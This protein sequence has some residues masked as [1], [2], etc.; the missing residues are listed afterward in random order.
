MNIFINS[1]KYLFSPIF[2]NSTFP[3]TPP[4]EFFFFSSNKN[5]LH[6]EPLKQHRKKSCLKITV[7]VLEVFMHKQSLK[8]YT[9]LCW[10]FKVSVPKINSDNRKITAAM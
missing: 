5:K 1:N 7:L 2:K 6:E 10:R 9:H 4:I 8:I 3:L